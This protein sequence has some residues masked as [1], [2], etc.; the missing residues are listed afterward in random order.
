MIPLRLLNMVIITNTAVAG[1]ET[2]RVQGIAGIVGTASN[3][4]VA[5]EI[6][7]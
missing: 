3:G 1:R 2:N 4:S 7:Y 6:D 5:D